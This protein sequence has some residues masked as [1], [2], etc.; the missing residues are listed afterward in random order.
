MLVVRE[1]WAKS[2]DLE[3]FSAILAALP[4]PVVDLNSQMFKPV[5]S[6]HEGLVCNKV[7]A[8][9][10]LPGSRYLPYKVRL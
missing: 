9:K 6:I 4:P 5:N 2:G 3:R 7:G 8:P 1:K 10:L